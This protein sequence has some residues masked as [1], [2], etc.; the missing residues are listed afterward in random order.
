LPEGKIMGRREDEELV[1]RVWST[2]DVKTIDEDKGIITGIATTPSTDRMGDI[3]EPKGAKFKLPMPLL[4]QHDKDNPIGKVIAAQAT[5]DGIAI[6]AQVFKGVTARID[7]AWA[8]IKSRLGAGLSIGFKPIEMEP[9]KDSKT[10]GLRFLK[11]DWLELS[12][13]TIAANAD[14]SIQTIKSIDDQQMR[15]ALGTAA[16]PSLS[17]SKSSPGASGKSARP[18]VRHNAMKTTNET[19]SEYEA[20]RA[21]NAAR[22][23]ALMEKSNADGE[24]LDGE[25]AGEYDGL[26]TEIKNIDGH[27]TRLKQLALIQTS[28]AREITPD[29]G[30]DPDAASR[31]RGDDGEKSSST[32][33]VSVRRN[34]PAG[35][36]FARYAQCLAFGKGNLMQA[37]QRALIYKDTPEL[38]PILK[39]AMDAGTTTDSTWALPLWQYQT[40]ASEFIELLRPDTIVGKIQGLRRVPFNIRVASKTQGSTVGWVGQGSPKPVSELAFSELTLGLA[41]AAGIVVIS[42]ELARSASPSAEAIIRQDLVDTMST[43]MDVQF[44]SPSVAAVS[45]VSPASITNGLT[46]V[47]STGSSV[48]TV[49]ADLKSLLSN[50]INNDIPSR[51]PYFVMHPITALGLSLLRTAQDIFA[52][53]DITH[54]GGSLF[55]IPVVTSR[56]VPKTTSGGSIIVLL[57]ASEIFFADDGQVTLDASEQASLQMDS[58]PSAGAQSVVSLWQNNLIGIR[59]ERYMNWKRARDTA[60][61]YL[62]FVPVY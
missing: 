14:A 26:A 56:S 11:W 58:A 8:L 38:A 5:D 6:T 54:K 41:K 4:F 62:D 43:F 57:D 9:I 20:K 40:M 29:V 46:A 59:A 42:Q 53:P 15:A 3:V 12:A 28:Q 13:V 34:V 1:T 61:T 44:I 37:H 27:I 48:A 16:D 18:V 60:V 31:A 25:A 50:F 32:H 45:N 36:T 47:A 49:T 21:A 35:T 22:M 51:S 52:F 2:L 30:T 24:T 19:I 39:S 33:I 55:G 17:L 10:F 23:Q 7:E